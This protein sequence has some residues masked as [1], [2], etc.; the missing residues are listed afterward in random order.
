MEEAVKHGLVYTLQQK[1]IKKWKKVWLSLYSQ[2]SQSVARLEYCEY[3]EGSTMSERQSSKRM[4]RKLIR[5]SECISIFEVVSENY[6]K[7]SGVFAV[8]T[9]TKMYTFA[10]D[11][12]DCIEW[13]Q[14]LKETTFEYFQEDYSDGMTIRMQENELYC[15]QAGV[16]DYTVTVR[17]TDASERCE[18][19]G[20]YFLTLDKEVL[21]LKNIV[22]EEVVYEWPYRYLRRFGGDTRIFSFESGRSSKSGPGKFEFETKHGK[23]IVCSVNAAVKI[24]RENSDEERNHFDSLENDNSL[25]V[26]SATYKPHS[27]SPQ[28]VSKLS[29]M[30]RYP[31]EH[32]YQL[33]KKIPSAVLDVFEGIHHLSCED[34]SDNEARSPLRKSPVR[35][36]YSFPTSPLNSPRGELSSKLS[37]ETMENRTM[38]HSKPS[39]RGAN[40]TVPLE[41]PS[42]SKS[43][44]RQVGRQQ[45]NSFTYSKGG[46]PPHQT[47]E[48]F[49]R[50]ST[51][52]HIRDTAEINLAQKKIPSIVMSDCSKTV[53]GAVHSGYQAAG[54]LKALKKQTTEQETKE[55]IYDEVASQNDF[56]L[57]D[58]AKVLT[59][60]WK[61]QGTVN[62]SFGYEYPYNS[63]ADD[64][65]V[66]KQVFMDGPPRPRKKGPSL[67][68]GHM[69]N[70]DYVNMKSIICN[71][72]PCN[73]L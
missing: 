7:E 59:E 5:M 26:E 62:D 4:D 41:R 1:F 67:L 42:N 22:S 60:A 12:S 17:S 6:P 23:Q 47:N 9:T 48:H 10:T 40:L 44:P 51:K 73:D 53:Y 28:S 65:A 13:V 8:E 45:T 21:M 33:S 29:E 2:S 68:R 54:D 3:K 64:Y 24:Q 27:G 19:S 71:R 72:D 36:Q 49:V 66:P 43:L 61:V 38:F 34:G 14:K 50:S 25:T 57:Y 18:L 30:C 63:I 15:T 58:E 55:P 11:K 37:T 46:S 32:K 70:N 52:T 35:F 16:N 69:Q 20:M 56:S 39:S 31:K